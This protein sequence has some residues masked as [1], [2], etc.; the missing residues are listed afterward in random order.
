MKRILLSLI[1]GLLLLSKAHAGDGDQYIT[2]NAGLLFQNTLNATFGY[3]K[4][5]PYD[6]AFEI[7]GEAG[8]RWARD[9]ECGKVCS[10][11]FWKQYYWNGGIVYKKSLVRW[12][13]S[14]LRLDLGPVAGAYRG[15]YFFGAEGS[16]EYNYTLVNGW[17]LTIK[18]KNN[19]NFMHG[20]TFRNGLTIGIKV[21]L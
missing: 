8:N 7:F 4:E 11:S 1:L 20:D 2:L 15:D 5:L 21:P 16:L 13:N 14:T 12:K 9:L 17:K 18:Q 6:N 3:E 10:K 19:V